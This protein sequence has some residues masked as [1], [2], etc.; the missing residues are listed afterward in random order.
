MDGLHVPHPLELL[1]EP[2]YQGMDVEHMQIFQLLHAI[3]GGQQADVA[4][5]LHLAPVPAAEA[6]DGH[7]HFPGGLAGPENIGG[8]AAA[9]EYDQ[10][11]APAGQCP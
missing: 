5:G 2:A 8:I 11:I 9:A 6:D 3:G 4:Q 10:Q 1:L 7:A